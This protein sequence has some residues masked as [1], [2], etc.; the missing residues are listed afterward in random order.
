M[1]NGP[2]VRTVLSTRAEICGVEKL[3]PR[4]NWAAGWLQQTSETLAVLAGPLRTFA[5]PVV[6]EQPNNRAQ[7][8]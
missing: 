7:C 2:V 6:I 4:V 5:S 3:G 1:I 8:T